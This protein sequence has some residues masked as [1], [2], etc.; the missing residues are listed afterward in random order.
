MIRLVLVCISQ[1]RFLGALVQWN[2]KYY[3][4]EKKGSGVLK[5]WKLLG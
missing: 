4:W 3:Y 5:V 2:S 1:S